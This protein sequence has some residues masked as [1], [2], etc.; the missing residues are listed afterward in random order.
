[1]ISALRQCSL[2]WNL[3]QTVYPV[4]C[5]R[6]DCNRR[7]A[8]PLTSVALLYSWQQSA[9]RC[10]SQTEILVFV[11]LPIRICTDD[12]P[13]ISADGVLRHFIITGNGSHPSV[14]AFFIDQF[15]IVQCILNF[16]LDCAKFDELATSSKLYSFTN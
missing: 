12:E 8:S 15:S 13:R 11:R 5:S 10:L 14:L 7:L 1:M 2:G 9:T 16:S 6:V 4:D 3:T